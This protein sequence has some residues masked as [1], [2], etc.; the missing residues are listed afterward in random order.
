MNTRLVAVVVVVMCGMAVVAGCD[1]RS[2]G[3]GSSSSRSSSLPIQPPTTAPSTKVLAG[4]RKIV[5][6]QF[7]MKVEDIDV[8]KPLS[9]YK[10]DELDLVELVMEC[11]DQFHV[12]I[13]D[14]AIEKLAG[15]K[16]PAR[17]LQLTPAHFARAVEDAPPQKQPPADAA[18][19]AP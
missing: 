14:E 2:A 6:E 5:A 9:A 10:A 18:P 1:D 7:E 8:N 11:E 4:V 12:G 15:S 13:S 17:A 19:A 16:E 3:S